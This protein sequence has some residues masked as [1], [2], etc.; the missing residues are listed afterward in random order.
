MW[1]IWGLPIHWGIATQPGEAKAHPRCLSS[2]L[3]FKRKTNDF[4]QTMK[5]KST[6][7]RPCGLSVDKQQEVKF[8]RGLQRF[9][10]S[11]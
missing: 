1:V 9:K 7:G 10:D 4:A 2:K 6:E 8:A 3:G 5:N 11:K